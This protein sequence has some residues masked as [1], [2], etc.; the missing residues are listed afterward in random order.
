MTPIKDYTPCG[1][2][3]RQST[4][5]QYRLTERDKQ[6]IKSFAVDGLVPL[7]MYLYAL[8]RLPDQH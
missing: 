6:Y 1:L 5:K 7:D 4:V 8:G 3:V 2:P